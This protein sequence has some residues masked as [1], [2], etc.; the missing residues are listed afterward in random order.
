MHTSNKQQTETET[1]NFWIQVLYI[2]DI[3]EM[4][5]LFVMVATKSCT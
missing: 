4:A 2:A 5:L 1:Q 3:C